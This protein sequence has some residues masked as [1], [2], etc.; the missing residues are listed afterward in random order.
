MR[1][2]TKKRENLEI[3]LLSESSQHHKATYCIIPTRVLE[4]EKT[5]EQCVPQ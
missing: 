3:I 4:R 1:Y 5:M 2:Q